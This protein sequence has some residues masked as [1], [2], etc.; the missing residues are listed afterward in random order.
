MDHAFYQLNTMLIEMGLQ[1]SLHAI[2]LI[3]LNGVACEL[4]E[5][6]APSKLFKR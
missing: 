4:S 6:G 5:P 3:L 2:K 1:S